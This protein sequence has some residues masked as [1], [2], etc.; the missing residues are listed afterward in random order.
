MRELWKCRVI[1]ALVLGFAIATGGGVAQENTQG[2]DAKVSA[3]STSMRVFELSEPV[4]PDLLSILKKEFQVVSV[5]P[6]IL[7]A[8]GT[9]EQ[10]QA[11]ATMLAALEKETANRE[12]GKETRLLVS[13]VLAYNEARELS[14]SAI[15][16][17]LMP[18][19]KELQGIFPYKAYSLLDTIPA[20]IG[21]NGDSF[22][23]MTE[24]SGCAANPNVKCSQGIAIRDVVARDVVS[25]GSFIYNINKRPT[26]GADGK[27]IDGSMLS[28]IKTALQ[29]APGE[30][31]VVGKL[32]A[33]SGDGAYFV[34]LTVQN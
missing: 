5:S 33:M 15:P 28:D 7:A 9:G 21:P 18:A 29:I 4:R 20:V 23:T 24:L 2:N 32:N 10:M 14:G 26:L 3:A 22:T 12:Q 30:T 27:T 11:I 31:V 6:R 25:I 19:V 13:V 1:A 17:R 8:K 34:I 16:G